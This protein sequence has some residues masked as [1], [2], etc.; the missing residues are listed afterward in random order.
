MAI[1]A[2]TP[3]LPNQKKTVLQNRPTHW[4]TCITVVNCSSVA[5]LY[6]MRS[7]YCIWSCNEQNILNLIIVKDCSLLGCSGHCLPL[8]CLELQFFHPSV[9][10]S[11]PMQVPLLPW[12]WRQQVR[13]LCWYLST[14]HHIPEDF[15]ICI[16]RR[17]RYCCYL[18]NC[19]EHYKSLMYSYYSVPLTLDEDCD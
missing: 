15:P 17:Y 16:H 5:V 10:P 7:G 9:C 2:S 4:R 3:L 8:A 14:W 13:P 1:A 19:T 12:R 11:L 18:Y 6:C